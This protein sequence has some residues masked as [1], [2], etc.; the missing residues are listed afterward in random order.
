MAEF[1]LKNNYFEFD[2]CIK[3]Q[4]SGTAVGTKVVPSYACIFMNKMESFLS[5]R[6]QNHGYG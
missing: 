4:I 6:M 1:E 5:H 2:S 3:Q